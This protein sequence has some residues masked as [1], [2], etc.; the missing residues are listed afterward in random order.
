V[1]SRRPARAQVH[2]GPVLGLEIA[3][4]SLFGDT[5]DIPSDQCVR[6]GDHFDI[7]L[8]PLDNSFWLTGKYMKLGGQLG[9]LWGTWVRRAEAE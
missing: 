2:H 9:K 1:E 8:D 7:E 5:P 3:K 4:P 6:W